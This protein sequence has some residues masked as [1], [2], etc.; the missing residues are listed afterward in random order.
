MKLSFEPTTNNMA[1]MHAV[2]SISSIRNGAVLKP[3]ARIIFS[4]KSS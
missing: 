1:A 2:N 4:R 3:R